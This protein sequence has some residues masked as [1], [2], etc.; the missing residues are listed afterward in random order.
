MSLFFL[1]SVDLLF[2]LHRSLPHSTVTALLLLASPHRVGLCGLRTAFL[3]R[4]LAA[5]MMSVVQVSR[6]RQQQRDLTC[7][8]DSLLLILAGQA[9]GGPWVSLKHFRRGPREIGFGGLP[10]A[11]EA[12]DLCCYNISVSQAGRFRSPLAA[13]QKLI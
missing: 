13:H 10:G 2:P 7:S 11:D 3:L 12:Y 9:D 1:T 5:A 6:W 4:D 8:N